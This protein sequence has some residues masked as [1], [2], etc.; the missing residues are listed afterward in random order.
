[1][2]D[3]FHDVFLD[4]HVKFFYPTDEMFIVTSYTTGTHHK[5]RQLGDVANVSSLDYIFMI[6]KGVELCVIKI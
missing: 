4:A 6:E 5:G 1:M 3:D 2:L